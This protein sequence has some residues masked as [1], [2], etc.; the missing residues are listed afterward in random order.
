MLDRYTIIKYLEFLFNNI[1]NL[2]YDEF[3]DYLNNLKISVIDYNMQDKINE[4]Y[5]EI[6]L[7]ENNKNISIQDQIDTVNDF[8]NNFKNYLITS[9]K[10]SKILELKLSLID[11]LSKDLYSFLLQHQSVRNTKKGYK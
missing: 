5:Y 11:L 6:L 1:N 4:L 10:S 3:Y 9:K 7:N 8:L 2:N